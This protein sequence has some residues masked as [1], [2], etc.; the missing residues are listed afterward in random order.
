ME[1]DY[2]VAY[3]YD[4]T[5]EGLLSAVFLAYARK[6]SPIDIVDE[7]AFVPRLGQD[8]VHVETDMGHAQ[9]VRS[10]I[11]RAC[12]QVVFDAVVLVAAS[13]DPAKGAA[14]LR[15]IRYAM[16]RGRRALDDLAHPDVVDFAAINRFVSNERHQWQQ[17]M[18]FSK[19]EGGV[20]VARCN[21]KANVVPLLMDWFSMRFNT[22]PFL[23][24]DEVH[25]VAGVS[26]QGQ[27]RLVRTDGLTV[28]PPVAEDALIQQAWCTFYDTVAVEARY[29]PELRRTHMP[30]RMW[31]NIVEVQDK[32]ETGLAK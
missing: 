5:L 31:K 29:N 22:Q 9:R 13:D 16:A 27:W 17:F 11:V 2:D 7:S 21:P 15:F 3:V 28:P 19:V 1:I 12:G 23:I 30:K 18:R 25:N 20:Y 8:T 24:Y 10:G 32:I 14:T 6:Q 26:Y 4:G